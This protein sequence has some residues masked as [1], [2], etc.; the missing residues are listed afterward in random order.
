[1][2]EPR[3]EGRHIQVSTR[4]AECSSPR[5]GTRRQQ[6]ETPAKSAGIR[7]EN[8][9]AA[10]TMLSVGPG[11]GQPP[12]PLPPP[13]FVNR[14][15]VRPP[16]ACSTASFYPQSSWPDNRLFGGHKI[17]AFYVALP[18]FAFFFPSFFQR[19]LVE[20][21]F[22]CELQVGLMWYFKHT[23]FILT[24]TAFLEYISTLP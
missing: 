9:V 18:S 23:G 4:P 11:G 19:H 24:K 10:R 8:R 1:M 2:S 6:M 7:C 21:D 5:Y 22:L 20:S 3:P 14:P 15:P 17:L 16:L 13:L 12:P